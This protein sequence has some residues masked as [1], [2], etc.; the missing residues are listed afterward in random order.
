MD[1]TITNGGTFGSMLSTPVINVPHCRCRPTHCSQTLLINL[2][3]CVGMVPGGQ[4][5]GREVDSGPGW[6]AASDI[7]S[8]SL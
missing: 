3:V 2:R 4:H 1:V 7:G 6:H 5:G 8:L